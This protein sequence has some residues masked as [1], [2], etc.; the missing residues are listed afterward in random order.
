[1]M[2]DF[3]YFSHLCWP[4]PFQTNPQE[5]LLSRMNLS[6]TIPSS[7]GNLGLLENLELYGNKL[8][9]E[10]PN[11]SGNKNLKVSRP[12]ASIY[13]LLFSNCN[14]WQIL[15]YTHFFRLFIF[16]SFSMHEE[17]RFIQLSF[18]RHIPSFVDEIADAADH[19]PQVEQYQRDFT[20]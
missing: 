1:M 4:T 8:I 13:L 16:F 6:S 9:G 2:C 3:S 20:Q 15:K 10:L 17:N 19:P 5:I 11:L 7:L 12:R 18:I 14:D